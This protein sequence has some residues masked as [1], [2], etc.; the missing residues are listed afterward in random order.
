MG[1]Q[2]YA[3]QSTF[4]VEMQST[5]E[6]AC[7]GKLMYEPLLKAFI[8]AGCKLPFRNF[9]VSSGPKSQKR[10]IPPRCAEADR[11]GLPA[12]RTPPR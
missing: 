6:M 12:L 8:A 9:L 1:S 10:G 4:G 5:G 2:L 3:L 11:D 7:F